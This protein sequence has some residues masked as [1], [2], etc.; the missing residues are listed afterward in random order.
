LVT[1][2]IKGK[3]KFPLPLSHVFSATKPAIKTINTPKLKERER[4]RDLERDKER[5]IRK[6]KSRVRELARLN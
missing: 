2:K 4:E 5:K 1:K 6:I 3:H